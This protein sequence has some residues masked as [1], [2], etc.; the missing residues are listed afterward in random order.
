MAKPIVWSEQA[1]SKAEKSQRSPRKVMLDAINEQIK[2]VDA[3]I[4]GE[5]YTVPRTKVSKGADGSHV[6][7][8]IRIMPRRMFWKSDDGRWL[9]GLRYGGR[10]ALELSPGKPSIA[11]GGSLNEVLAV[12]D[13]VKNAIE[14]GE[15]DEAIRVTIVKIKWKR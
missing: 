15:M 14:T 8:E 1:Q 4:R 11:A 9:V 3:E 6:K 10:I 5:T 2:I 13:I 7:N 12:L